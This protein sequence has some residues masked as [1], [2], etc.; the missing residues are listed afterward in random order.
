MGRGAW[1]ATIHGG[2]KSQTQQVTNTFTFRM[3]YDK[4]GNSNC[5][6]MKPR[7]FHIQYLS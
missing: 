5:F 7:Q 3:I 4:Y 6:S 1:Q 2:T